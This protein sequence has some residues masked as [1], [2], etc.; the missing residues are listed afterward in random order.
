M[1]MS[2]ELHMYEQLPLFGV[3]LALGIV[4]VLGHVLMLLQVERGMEFARNFSRNDRLGQV[5][6]YVG[7]AWFWLLCLPKSSV[8]GFLSMSFGDEFNGLK[9]ILVF[10]LPVLAVLVVRS[11]QDFLAVRALGL[12]GLQAAMPLLG[13]AFLKDPQS[14]LLVPTYAYA[15]IVAS[16][17]MVGKPYLFR[18]VIVWVTARASRWKMSAVLGILYGVAVVVCA[19]MFWRGY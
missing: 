11:M 10:G 14:R 9:P 4:L 8:L 19:L 13:A 3:G 12:L 17:F 18:D 6:L 15:M 2:S 5:L 1:A 16:L 7:I